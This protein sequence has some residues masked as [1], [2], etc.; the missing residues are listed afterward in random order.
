MPSWSVKV[1]RLTR[2]LLR[3]S[4]LVEAFDHAGIH[5]AKR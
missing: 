1:D 3:F 5:S 2:S 4:K